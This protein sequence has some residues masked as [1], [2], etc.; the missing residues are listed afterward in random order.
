MRARTLALV[1]SATVAVVT[2]AFS[3][4]AVAGT[5][6]VTGVPI[7]TEQQICADLFGGI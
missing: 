2:F 5:T 7:A 3:P 1:A 4:T 6:G